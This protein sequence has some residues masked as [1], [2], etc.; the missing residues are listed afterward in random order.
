MGG[1]NPDR[2]SGLNEKRLIGLENEQRLDDGSERLRI[3]GR[4]PPSPVDDEIL[5]VLRYFGV[6]IVLQAAQCRLLQ[7]ALGIEVVPV[8]GR[9]YHQF[10]LARSD[11][12]S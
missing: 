2:L 10:I 1:E 12:A 11:R 8:K 7:P 4:F 6:E 3:T 9:S 5:W